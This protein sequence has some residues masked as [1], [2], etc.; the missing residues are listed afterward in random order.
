[1]ITLLPKAEN[2]LAN[3]HPIT[4]APIIS[5]FFG[6]ILK[7][8]DNISSLVKILSWSILNAGISAGEEP[9]AIITLFALITF[10]S[11]PSIEISK[12]SLAFPPKIFPCPIKTSF[13]HAFSNAAIPPV[14][15]ETIL[16]L[17]ST[18]LPKSN[19]I[20]QVT[21][22]SSPFSL[23]RCISSADAYK[24]LVG[25]QPTFK[26]V[27]PRLFFS[28]KATLAPYWAALIAEW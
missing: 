18:A 26:Q 14:N 10:F 28:I 7:S 2:I 4:P 8:G 23:I 12:P 21:P 5:N 22:S 19:F 27:P 24:A 25:I 13:F 17:R 11:S 15:S 9:V 3:S 1:M 6:T 20:S 16:F